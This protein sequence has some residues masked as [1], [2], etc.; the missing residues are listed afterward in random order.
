MRISPFFHNL[1]TAYLAELED[2]NFDTDGHDVL[3]QRLKEKRQEISF[4]VQMMEISP[5]MVAVVFHQ[6]FSFKQTSVME[7]VLSHES[8]EL[9][10]WSHI[11]DSIT[12]APWAQP[13][14]DVILSAPGGEQFLAVT[15]ALQ[16]MAGQP[17]PLAAQRGNAAADDED[18]EAN[19]EDD[20]DEFDLDENGEDPGDA[21]ARKDAAGDWMVGQ[22][23]DRKD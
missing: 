13:L 11:S 18:D 2:L 16:Y 14:V 4:L 23:F 6:G 19:D 9:L 8:D 15:A 21:R 5:E 22:G 20:Q 7:Q 12:L 3:Q 1:R 10:Q 17:D